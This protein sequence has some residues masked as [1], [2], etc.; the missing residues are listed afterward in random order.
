MSDNSQKPLRPMLPVR[1]LPNLF[2]I[3]IASISL[4]DIQQQM[5]FPFFSLSKKPDLEIRRYK[6]RHN[7]SL[8]IT[9]SVMGLPTIYDKDFLIYAISQVMDRLNRG[10]PVSRRLILYASDM[11]EFANR[12][13]SGRDYLAIEDALLRLSG[14][15]IKTNIR[16]G[17]IY[18]TSIFGL[19]ERG[20]LIRKYGFNGRL[21]HVEVTLSE[22]LWNAIEAR[23]VLTLHP[24]YFR[25]RQ[26]LERRIYEIARKHCGKQSEWQISLDL[27]HQKCGS[28]SRLWEFRRSVRKL[29][30]HGHLLD[31]AVTFD[32]DEDMVV[33]HRQEG[34]LVDRIPVANGRSEIELPESVAIEARR[35][36]G[37]AVD[38]AAAERDWRRWM[39][40]KDVRPSNPAAL[41]LSFLATW[42]DRQPDQDADG[43]DDLDWIGQ[44]AT[45]WWG[46]LDGAERQSLRLEVGERIELDD[47]EGW[48]RSEVSMA[49]DAFDRRWRRQHCA[50]GD[51]EL[52][53]QLLARAARAAGAD[54][55]PE[56]IEAGWRGWIV[57]QPSWMQDSLMMSVM[58]YAR[59][60]V[61]E[62]QQS[63][64]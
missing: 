62:D 46:T 7:N 27:L 54:A 20:D 64:D 12:T 3:D 37:P 45:E 28:R 44:M 8:Q 34:S 4:K 13:K 36:H 63:G 22:W 38:L 53:P 2:S 32:A 50:P 10:E 31:Y 58:S 15:R 17:D 5:E 6:D 60:L 51:M 39:D 16:T 55:D 42:I 30:T 9:P 48:Y 1:H 26:P 24:D 23:Q 19:I 52:P 41:F 14:C 61:G 11:L 35:R 47:G 57:D 40:R 59:Q 43:D 33:F 49:R 56:A 21:Q 25:L 29:V 18:Q